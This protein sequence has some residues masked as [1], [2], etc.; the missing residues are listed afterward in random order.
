M[1]TKCNSIGGHGQLAYSIRSS[2]SG[3]ATG[4]GVGATYVCVCVCSRRRQK[5][6]VKVR[7]K[8]RPRRPATRTSWTYRVTWQHTR[9]HA[10]T[11][12]HCRK[13][14]PTCCTTAT[15]PHTRTQ[16]WYLYAVWLYELVCVCVY[17]YLLHHGGSCDRSTSPV[18]HA[19]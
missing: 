1:H 12:I 4:G 3:T 16:P 10:H 17:W 18:A 11:H 14:V 15:F 5:G 9:T 13:Q 7:W 8:W 19:V 2:A 6:S